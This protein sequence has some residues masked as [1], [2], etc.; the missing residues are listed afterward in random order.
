MRQPPEDQGPGPGRFPGPGNVA[1]GIAVGFALG[2][3]T[4]HLG[5][6]LPIGMLLGF[7]WDAIRARKR[8]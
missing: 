7:A 8:R 2:V 5:V 4:G 1:A 3:A 6:W